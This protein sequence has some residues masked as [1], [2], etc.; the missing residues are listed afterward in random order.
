MKVNNQ[1]FGFSDAMFAGGPY[2][3]AGVVGAV[4]APVDG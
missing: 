4:A 3:T 2:T 1:S